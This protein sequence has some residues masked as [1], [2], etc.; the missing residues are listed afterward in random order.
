MPL[1]QIFTYAYIANS[2]R[3]LSKYDI[4]LQV[5][6]VMN[7]LVFLIGVLHFLRAYNAPVGC[8]LFN[9]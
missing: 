2:Y 3:F 7:I 6:Q 5:I 8:A 1:F 9:Y 4:L